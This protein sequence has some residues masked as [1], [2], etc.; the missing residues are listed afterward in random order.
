[1]RLGAMVVREVPPEGV[2]EQAA[3]L[4]DGLDELWVVE[5]MEWSGGVAQAALLLAHLPRI[6]IGHGIAP[7]PFRHPVALAME[8]AALARAHPGRLHGG[9]GHGVQEWMAQLGLGA[10]SPLTLLEETASVVRDL[11]VGG[12]VTTRGRYVTADGVA[13][14]FPPNS[15]PP[16]SLGVR[17]PR[18]LELAGRCADGTVLAE[19]SS[20]AYVHW[21]R[22]RIADGAAAAGRDAASHHITV[23]CGIHIADTTDDAR[24]A[25]HAAAE[26]VRRRPEVL[27]MALPDR[28]PGAPAPSAGD[29]LAAASA[30][31]DADHAANHLRALA[32]A[33]AGTVILVPFGDDPAA[34]LRRAISTVAGAV[35]P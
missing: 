5:D 24:A 34:I 31:G 19:W 32:G 23:F 7:A 18:S 29:L 26:A 3:A 8:W 11:L 13:L 6:T 25:A 17:G 15:P 10:E 14:K 1:M 9:I 4:A 16:V 28:E 27:R 30:V 33:G 12:R 22:Q 35:R 2:V 21:A 20:P